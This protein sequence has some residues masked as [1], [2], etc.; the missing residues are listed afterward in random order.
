MDDMIDIWVLYFLFRG[1][2][3]VKICLFIWLLREK[4]W[5]VGTGIN[6]YQGKKKWWN[7]YLQPCAARSCF[8]RQLRLNVIAII[9]ALIRYGTLL[10]TF[11]IG[12]M[13]RHSLTPYPHGL[14]QV[15]NLALR[16][17]K[18]TLLFCGVG[19]RGRCPRDGRP[20]RTC[21]LVAISQHSHG[22]D[23]S[24]LVL[25]TWPSTD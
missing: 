8:S 13:L 9:N 22:W 3:I 10:G 11:L 5:E 14:L 16:G 21:F 7:W 6:S 25:L 24:R 2:H 4:D 23:T 1:L 20:R 17:C 15:I 19:G 18:S 12:T